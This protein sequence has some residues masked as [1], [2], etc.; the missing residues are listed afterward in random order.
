MLAMAYGTIF[1]QC[2]HVFRE[3]SVTLSPFII[4]TGYLPHKLFKSGG[5]IFYANIPLTLCHA[6]IVRQLFTSMRNIVTF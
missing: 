3:L 1:L 6:D 4:S 5:G 2:L